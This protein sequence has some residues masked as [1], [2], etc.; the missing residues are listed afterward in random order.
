MDDI[1]AFVFKGILTDVALDRNKNLVKDDSLDTEQI[2][3]ALSF[4]LLEKSKI[5]NATLMS[6]V[7][8]ALHSLENMIR[9]FVVKQL[10][11]QFN[12]EWTDKIPSKIK[13]NAES[14]KQNEE[15]I[16]WHTRREHDYMYWQFGDLAQ[17]IVD[18]WESFKDIVPN[19]HWVNNI[20]G[21]LEISRNVIMHGGVL[22]RNDI[23]RIGMSIRDW[24]RQIG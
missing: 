17:I 9:D 24:I 4:D 23:E 14:R 6:Y 11:E 16:K 20:L 15:K 1:Y 19:Q 2:Q 18:N 22:E 21:N 5:Q 8:V 10:S 12:E 3:R 13:K 7:Y